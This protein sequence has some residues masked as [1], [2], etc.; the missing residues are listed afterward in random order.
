MNANVLTPCA[1]DVSHRTGMPDFVFWCPGCHCG[2]GVWTSK[3]NHL[4]AQWIFN[5]DMVKPTFQPSLLLEAVGKS[6][7]CHSFITDGRIQ[8]LPD[9]THALAGQTV[10]MKPEE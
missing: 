2:H 4:G 7:R 8:F 6:P 5:G 9:C 3:P 10:E 1:P